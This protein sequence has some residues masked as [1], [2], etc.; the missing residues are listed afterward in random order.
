MKSTRQM[1]SEVGDMTLNSSDNERR[2]TESARNEGKRRHEVQVTRGMG[3]RGK[4]RRQEE[5]RHGAS[6]STAINSLPCCELTSA[7]AGGIGSGN[8]LQLHRVLKRTHRWNVSLCC[9]LTMETV[10]C[11]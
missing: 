10:G 7:K 6:G 9:C 2:G 5:A 1:A 4:R 11:S 8:A 3:I